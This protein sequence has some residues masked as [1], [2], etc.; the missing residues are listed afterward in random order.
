MSVCFGAWKVGFINKLLAPYFR[1]F[2][3]RLNATYRLAPRA[4]AP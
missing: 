2:Q 4:A 3:W 1:L